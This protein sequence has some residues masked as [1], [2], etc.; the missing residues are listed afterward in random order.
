MEQKISPQV[1][2]SYSWDSDSHKEKVKDF[3][4]QLRANGINVIYDGDLQLGKRLPHFME[5][6]I[7]TSDFV[8]F[9]CTHKYKERADR[10]KA[11]V[12]YENQIITSE[13]FKTCNE[14]KFIPVLFSGTWEFSLP[15]WAEGK[16]GIDLS[17]PELYDTNFQKLL[18]NLWNGI[19]NI[20]PSEVTLNHTNTEFSTDG[21][22]SDIPCS[23]KKFV[24]RVKNFFNPSTFVGLLLVTVIGGVIVNALQPFI[25]PPASSSSNS[26]SD[27]SSNH[28][29]FI[30][31]EAVKHGIANM[32]TIILDAIDN[33]KSHD[34]I[35]NTSTPHNTIISN[36]TMAKGTKPT[37]IP[38]PD[39]TE[40]K[41]SSLQELSI[42][43]SR[44]WIEEKL[45]VP[46]AEKTMQIKDNKLLLP[47][48][49]PTNKTGDILVCVYNISYIAA[50]Q[51]YYDISDNSCQGFFV[52]LLQDISDIEI[53]LPNL[54]SSLVSGKTLGEFPFSD[55]GDIP[56]Y[57]YGFSSFGDARTF[58]GEEHY[59][60]AFSNYRTL[61]FAVLD[62]GMLSS[63]EDFILFMSDIQE[64]IPPAI[65]AIDS[66]EAIT[67]PLPDKLGFQRVKFYP[68]TY[69]ISILDSHLTFDLI[70][71]YLWFD[72]LSLRSEPTKDL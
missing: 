65:E 46:Y 66:V 6:S 29:N 71:N 36:G 31:H 58:Y 45:G 47:G 67:S 18:S 50:V 7:S 1:F 51:V 62:Y 17:S 60:G 53:A 56:V 16:L 13:L 28:N 25:P 59:F 48:E 8:L 9:I 69:G 27:N 72:S 42:G 33:L 21:N 14:E 64:D 43:N 55:I 54:Y 68:N 3:A 70:T 63:R 20:N 26:I 24:G 34:A 37:T 15:K 32:S 44:K 38:L 30:S 52:T 2:I 39:G 35:S 41:I 11:G 12:G 57:T 5:D 40:E 61:Y 23:T 49:E 10:R 22:N 4:L 19:S